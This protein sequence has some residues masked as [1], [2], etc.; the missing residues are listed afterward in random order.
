MVQISGY[1]NRFKRI[2]FPELG[3]D[4]YVTIRNP[5]TQPPSKLKPEGIRLDEAGNP[6]DEDEAEVAMYKVLAT[7]I[8]DWH[9][10][11]AS[12]DEDEQPLLPL[13]ATAEAVGLLPMEIINKIA[14]ELAAAV[15]PN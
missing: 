8:R 1:D 2:D 15:N 11:D 6:V 13:P 5:K 12:S 10:Y 4:I 14:N 9:V 3:A 7:L